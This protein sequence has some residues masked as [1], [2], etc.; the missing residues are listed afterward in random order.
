[1]VGV[2]L[3]ATSAGGL[4]DVTWGL[5]APVARATRRALPVLHA[6]AVRDERKGRPH[7]VSRAD[8]R[9][10]FG[11]GADPADVASAVVVGQAARAETVAWFYPTFSAHDRLAALEALADVPAVVLVGEQDRVCPLEHSRALAGA[12]R[13]GELVVY[14]GAGHMLQLERRAEV[15][16]QLLALVDRALAA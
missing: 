3:V 4:S 5:P 1:M 13:A 14:P 10:M 7:K 6:K 2:A 11:P 8:L 16:R 15:S 9:L 12:L